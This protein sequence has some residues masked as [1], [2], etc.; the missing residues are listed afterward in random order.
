[1]VVNDVAATD[2]SVE[3]WY[4]MPELVDMSIVNVLQSTKDLN[5]FDEYMIL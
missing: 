5:N 4:V 2:R 1:M 3:D